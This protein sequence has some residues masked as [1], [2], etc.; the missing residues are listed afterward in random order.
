MLPTIREYAL[1]IRLK[2]RLRIPARDPERPPDRV[3]VGMSALI[4]R[5][6]SGSEVWLAK[7]LERLEL[8]AFGTPAAVEPI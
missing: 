5:R 8:L 4:A 2:V 7:L 6:L 1:V 3:G